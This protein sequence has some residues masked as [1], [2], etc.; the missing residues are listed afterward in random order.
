MVSLLC[1]INNF[2]INV[3][4]RNRKLKFKT[5][6]IWYIKSADHSQRSMSMIE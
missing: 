2:K 5:E 4:E 3:E 1:N 6:S